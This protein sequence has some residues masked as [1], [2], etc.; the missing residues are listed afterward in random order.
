MKYLIEPPPITLIKLESEE[1]HATHIIKV[2]VWRNPS[3]SASET[4]KINISTFNDGQPEE[5]LALM[6]NFKITIDGTGT[7]TA[8]GQIN[9]LY[10]ILC[11]TSLR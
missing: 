6:R 3:Q 2:R 8:S 1:L 4:Y 10:K 7:T 11:G 9:Y 5:F